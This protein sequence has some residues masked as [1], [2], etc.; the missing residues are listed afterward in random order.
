MGTATEIIPVREL[1]RRARSLYREEGPRSLAAVGGKFTHH[2][3]RVAYSTAVYRRRYGNAAPI[4]G[5]RLQLDPEAIEYVMGKVFPD[6]TPPFGVVDGRWDR[7]KLHRYEHG[8][9]WS[10]LKERYAD[11][12]DWV[13]TSYYQRGIERL[14]AGEMLRVLDTDEQSIEIFEQ[15]LQTIDNLYASMRT[16]GFDQSKPV[17]VNI[18]RNGEF[19][20]YADGNHRTTVADAA[21]LESIPVVV[22]YRHDRWQRIRLSVATADHTEHLH[23]DIQSK[24]AHPDLRPLVSSP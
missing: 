10:G 22:L 3:L 7:Q 20:L 12:R 8:E 18:G 16:D 15:Y 1:A 4:P 14:Q 17:P 19:I 11:N 6:D 23:P 21:G 13:E 24:L 9:M 2:W 5:E